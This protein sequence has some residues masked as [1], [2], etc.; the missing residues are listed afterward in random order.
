[1]VFK[2]ELLNFIPEDQ[3]CSLEEITFY[4]LIKRKELAAFVCEQRFYDMGSFK[5]LEAIKEVLR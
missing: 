5:E 2:K 1:M 3:T 4:E